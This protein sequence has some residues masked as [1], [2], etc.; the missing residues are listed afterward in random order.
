M[1]YYTVIRDVERKGQSVSN[2]EGRERET[3]REIEK[4]VEEPRLRTENQ[5]AAALRCVSAVGR[6]NDE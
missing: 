6:D 1:P 2:R 5:S 4:N 3:Y